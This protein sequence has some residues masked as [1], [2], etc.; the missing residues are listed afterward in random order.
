MLSLTVAVAGCGS[1][2]LTGKSRSDTTYEG[3]R[4]KSRAHR[5]EDDRSHFR[6]EVR[7]ATQS[8]DGAKA[9]GHHAGTRY[10]IEQYGSS[11]IDWISG[12]Y[13]ENESLILDGD[14]LV[15]EGICIV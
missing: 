1:F 3:V 6:V 12:P 7:R 14:T 15:M 10:C 8:L 5:V 9:S 4:F 2:S 13:Q 11:K